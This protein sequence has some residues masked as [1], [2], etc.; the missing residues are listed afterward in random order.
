MFSHIMQYLKKIYHYRELLF[1]LTYRD[2][3]ARYKGSYLGITWALLNPLVMLGIYSFIFITIFDLRWGLDNNNNKTLYTLMIFS[4]LVPFYIFSESINRSITVLSSNANYVKKVVFPLE[5][6]PIS[7][8]FSIV[9]NNM[10]GLFL[11]IVG[12][13]I[14]LDTA[15][16]TMIYIPLILIPLVLLSMGLSLALSALGVYIR[17]LVHAVGLI[18]N[19]LFYMSP[20]FYDSSIVPEPFNS[21]I[22]LN[23]LTSIITQIRNVILLGQPLDLNSYIITFVGSILVFIT[24]IGIFKYFRRGFSDVL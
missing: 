5:L 21:F 16:W 15:N 13:L 11:L 3:T 17:D 7:T 19:I 10:F 14:F 23:P 22:N 2:V 20:I 9:I 24:G 12:K 6:L 4:G 1:Q 8:V 18:V